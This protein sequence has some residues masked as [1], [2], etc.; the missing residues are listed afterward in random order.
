MSDCRRV[1]PD[2]L[3]QVLQVRD[4]RWKRLAQRS[5]IKLA[6]LEKIAA[7]LS[8][9]NVVMLCR[10]ADVLNVSTDHLLGRLDYLL[11][12]VRSVQIKEKGQ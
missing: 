8:L 9:P 5:Q 7:G 11:N 12:P 6:T 3:G 4:M 1:F 2:R 10:L